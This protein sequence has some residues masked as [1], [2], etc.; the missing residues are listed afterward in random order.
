MAAEQT[1]PE[2]RLWQLR[3]DFDRAFVDYLEHRRE[4]KTLTAED[5]FVDLYFSLLKFLNAM[6]LEGGAF[7]HFVERDGDESC[8]RILCKDASKF[9]GNVIDR[10]HSVIGL[11]ATL[12]PHAFYRDLLGFEPARTDRLS[13]PSPF[14]SENRQVVIDRNVA[15]VYKKRPENYPRI[16]ERLSRF[17][18]EVPGNVLAL[19][20]SYA[21]LAEVAS[22]LTTEHKRVLV[23]ARSDSDQE[24]DAILE[25]LRSA[26]LR[27][28][29]LLAVAGGVFAE[30]VDYPGDMLKAVAVIGPC[31]PALTLDQQLLQGYFDERFERGFEYAFVVPGMT[32]VVQAAGRL[33]R[34]ESDTGVIALMDK[35]FLFPAY[36]QHLPDDWS[37]D[38]DPR[39]LVGEPAEVAR[40][41]FRDVDFD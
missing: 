21:F 4:T 31:L 23:Q 18:D 1:F 13:L 35:R 17:A 20:P 32:R 40:R 11:S 15:T 37:M 5:R 30:G 14:P 3:A 39:Q 19:F 22:R 29:L 34:R 25:T 38:G 9:L 28:V 7:S 8:W 33:I 12:S 27:D 6:V 24:R 2:D 10:C 26:L 36:S 16:A 41:F